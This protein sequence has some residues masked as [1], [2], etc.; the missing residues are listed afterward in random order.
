MSLTNSGDDGTGNVGDSRSVPKG[1]R[2][3]I[4]GP[5][6]WGRPGGPTSQPGQRPQT[7]PTRRQMVGR[8]SSPPRVGR[9]ACFR[10]GG[11][12]WA[13]YRLLSPTALPSALGRGKTLIP[14]LPSS[15]LLLDRP[16]P[17]RALSRG[18]GPPASTTRV[19]ALSRRRG[20][21]G[22]R[23]GPPTPRRTEAS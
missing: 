17:P 16:P 5:D 23:G 19:G 3:H 6:P 21:F 7:S 4:Q 22:E 2:L 10:A 14:P 12:S 15:R 18:A 1:K 8:S 20:L 9:R 11:V 13:R